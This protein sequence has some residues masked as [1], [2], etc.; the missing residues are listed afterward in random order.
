M[1]HREVNNI[2]IYRQSL[3]F[4]PELANIKQDV[5]H[6]IKVIVNSAA[7]D[8][9]ENLY[10]IKK[11]YICLE[12]MLSYDVQLL[13]TSIVAHYYECDDGEYIIRQNISFRCFGCTIKSK[14]INERSLD[15]MSK[16]LIENAIPM[17]E[18]GE[19]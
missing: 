18:D 16:L 6:E 10:K 14:S 17:K 5:P 8:L 4:F 2:S 13:R 7:E 11:K 1:L 12:V 9:L 3:L 15:E 19:K